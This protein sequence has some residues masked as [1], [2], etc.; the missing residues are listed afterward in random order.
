VG[1][2][3]NVRVYEKFGLDGEPSVD[4]GAQRSRIDHVY[5]SFNAALTG[6]DAA[7]IQVVHEAYG[8]VPLTTT[9]MGDGKTYRVDFNGTGTEYGSLIEGRYTLTVDA[10]A[11]TDIHGRTLPGPDPVFDLH[12]W[13]G[14]EPRARE[15]DAPHRL[16]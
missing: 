12:R 11:V 3:S 4:G 7:A 14:L 10:N 5:L 8:S 1:I 16:Q 6:L 2:F 15:L 9:D 13:I